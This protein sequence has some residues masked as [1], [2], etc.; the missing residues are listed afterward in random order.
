M[1][2]KRVLGLD[3]GKAG[4]AVG[5]VLTELPENLEKFYTSL[6]KKKDFY[7]FTLDRESVERFLEIKPDAIVLEPT[8]GW[9][10][11]FWARLCERHNIEVNFVSHARLKAQREH[12]NFTNKTDY[13]DATVLAACYF[14]TAFQFYDGKKRFLRDYNPLESR[15]IRD[16]VLEMEQLDKM[17]G[18]LINQ[19]RQRLSFE[20]PELA[21]EALKRKGLGLTA[22]MTWLA[23][24]DEKPKAQRENHY[25]KSVAHLLGIE[26]SSHTRNHARLI[27]QIE[28]QL[29]ETE[30]ELSQLLDNPKFAIY[31]E[32]FDLYGFGLT[33][34]GMLLYKIYPLEKFLIDGKPLLLYKKNDAGETVKVDRSQSFF[35]SYLGLSKSISQSGDGLKTNWNGSSMLRSHLYIWT[36]GQIAVN[37]GRTTPKRVELGEKWDGL[38]AKGVKGKDAIIRCCYALTRGLYRELLK[39]IE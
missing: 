17:R 30:N 6:D 35:Q 8:G 24:A 36:M 16:C 29:I 11:S 32:V 34:R 7:H 14:D 5:L 15:S 31:N 18:S 19:I 38:R 20:Y 28:C 22:S 13:E 3:I 1:K 39:R 23:E 10:S 12:F 25:K 26:I 4:F 37:K 27:N 21:T 33:M 9:Y 2:S